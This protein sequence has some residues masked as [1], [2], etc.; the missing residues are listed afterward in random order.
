MKTHYHVE[1]WDY[2]S[3]DYV[4]KGTACGA[5][6]AEG[7]INERDADDGFS[8]SYRIGLVSCEACKDTGAFSRG[9]M[10]ADM[11]TVGAATNIMEA[12]LMR[13]QGQTY[14]HIPP[15]AA[16]VHTFAQEGETETVQTWIV[17]LGEGLAAAFYEGWF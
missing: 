10:L 3:A 12:S 4:S 13:E 8:P 17:P 6:I 11:V 1:E 14:E 2:Q 15:F 5:P 7:A 9:L 16:H